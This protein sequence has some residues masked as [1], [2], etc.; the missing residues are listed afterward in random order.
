MTAAIGKEIAVENC[1]I[2]NFEGLVTLTLDRVISHTVVYH[3]SI[4][5]YMPKFI[6]IEE[7]FVNVRTYA[8]TDIWDQF[9]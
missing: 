8:C 1:R 6:E 4:S 2:S 3:W 9:C 5:I 7:N